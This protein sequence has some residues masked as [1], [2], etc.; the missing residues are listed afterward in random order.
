MSN[1]VYLGNPLLKKA[2]TPIEFTKEQVEE[3]ILENDNMKLFMRE[4]KKPDVIEITDDNT[5]QLM[6]LREECKFISEEN[7]RFENYPKDDKV[8]LDYIE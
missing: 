6:K 2:N 5:I 4:K 7:Y 8:L 3:Y 1:D